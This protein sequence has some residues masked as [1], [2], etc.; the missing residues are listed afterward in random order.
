M[1][2]LMASSLSHHFGGLV[3]L[4]GAA[5]DVPEKTVVGLVGPNG[6]GKSTMLSVLSG[7]IAPDAGRIALG[8][9]DVS[10]A[11]P[12]V[13][14]QLGLVRTFQVPRE[15]AGL[16]VRS[17]VAVAAKGQIGEGLL[18][19]LLRGAS[20]RR[21][22]SA[23]AEKIDEVLELTGLTAV[24]D[25]CAGDLSGGQKKLLEL[26]R[27]LMTEPSVLLLDEPFAGVHPKLVDELIVK[28]RALRDRGISL[29]VVE[30]NMRAVA[31]LCDRVTVMVNGRTLMTGTAREIQQ[32]PRVLAA[33]LGGTDG[34]RHS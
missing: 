31:E 17:N 6:A 23:A 15:F 12:E 32:D 34:G 20:V 14:A 28:L 8:G 3:A 21:Q 1:K 29:L 10:S 33:Y 19:A 11:R 5:I 4:D 9:D 24:R 22:E 25:R 27:A 13:R 26:A 30:H 18:G 2:S 16:S 7:F